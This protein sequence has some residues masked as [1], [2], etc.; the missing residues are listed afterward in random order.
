V[1]RRRRG[2]RDVIAVVG[3]NE[4]LRIVITHKPEQETSNV[5]KA[6]TVQAFKSVSGIEV[7]EMNFTR[8]TVELQFR[9]PRSI[10]GA[11]SAAP[12]PATVGSVRDVGI[13]WYNN[14]EFIKLGGSVDD[15]AGIVSL[16]SA[17]PLGRYQVRNVLRATDFTISQMTPRKIFTPNGD[18]VN[19]EITLYLEN[20]KDSVLTQAKIF[21]ITGAEVAD[22]QQGV[23][24]GASSITS[25]K[26]DGRDKTG[27]T[28][29]SGVY[30][31]QVQAEGK[32]LNGT[33]VVAR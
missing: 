10:F 5:L 27:S 12:R 4:D 13:F 17:H 20:P 32:I 25:L 28:V 9:Y 8:P 22:F 21:D 15:S 31:Y 29:R 3:L 30:V 14:V 18:G 2:L 24:A 23:V 1:R 7:T 11:L 6:Y 26:W 19:D 16:M 33:I